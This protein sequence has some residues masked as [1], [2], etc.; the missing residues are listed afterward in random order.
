[1]IYFAYLSSSFVLSC[2][3]TLPLMNI[4]VVD[5]AVVLAV[6]IQERAST[7]RDVSL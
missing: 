3:F 5:V 1:M 2:I 6:A 4:V 7:K